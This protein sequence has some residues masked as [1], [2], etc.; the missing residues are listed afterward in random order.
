MPDGKC[1]ENCTE[2][3]MTMTK[4]KEFYRCHCT[5]GKVWMVNE[6]N[7]TNSSCVAKACPVNWVLNDKN[8]CV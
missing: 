4:D 2:R 5:H 1:H 6:S 8:V 7:V 3:N